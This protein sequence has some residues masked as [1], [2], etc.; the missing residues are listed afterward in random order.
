MAVETVKDYSGDL[1]EVV[2]ENVGSLAKG[3]TSDSEESGRSWLWILL[4]VVG[5]VVVL[6]VLRKRSAANTSEADTP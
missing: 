2:Q 5:V 4:L 3:L 1:L 6:A